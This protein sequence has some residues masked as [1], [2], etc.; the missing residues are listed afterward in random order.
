MMHLVLMAIS[1]ALTEQQ[2]KLTAEAKSSAAED[3]ATPVMYFDALVACLQSSGP[4]VSS[5]RVAAMLSLFSIVLENVS[6][7][8]LVVKFTTTATLFEAL[9]KKYAQPPIVIKPLL[10]CVSTLLIGQDSRISGNLANSLLTKLLQSLVDPHG[11]VRKYAVEY[12]LN[13][14]KKPALAQYTS[15]ML[16]HGISNTLN[17]TFKKNSDTRSAFHI[18][19]AL[20]I[21]IPF[22]STASLPQL[23]H[24]LLGIPTIGNVLMTQLAFRVFLAL[25]SASRMTAEADQLDEQASNEETENSA[26]ATANPPNDDEVDD[27]DDERDDDDDDENA[28]NDTPRTAPTFNSSTDVPQNLNAKLLHQFLKKLHDCEPN[29]ADTDLSISFA[30][31]ITEG[32]ITLHTLDAPGCALK[33]NGVFSML[34]LNLQDE[35]ERFGLKT[36]HCLIRLINACVDDEMIASTV[37][38][39]DREHLPLCRLIE[40]VHQCLNIKFRHNLDLIVDVITAL[41]KRL[42]QKSD[43]L[44]AIILQTLIDMRSTQDFHIQDSLHKAIGAAVAAMGPKQFLHYVPLTLSVDS[45]TPE[46]QDKQWM[47]PL[48]KEHISHAGLGF[49]SG[50]FLPIAER[51]EKRAQEL[52]DQEQPTT[53]KLMLNICDQIWALFPSFCDFATDVSESFTGI[54]R[55]LGD[56]LNTTE[57]V[58]TYI[59]TGFRRII[60]QNLAISSH[61][62]VKHPHVTPAQAQSNILTMQKFAKNYLP[63]LFNIYA[64]SS[65][66]AKADKAGKMHVLDTIAIYSSITKSEELNGHFTKV[67]DKLR[68][69]LQRQDAGEHMKDSKNGD[70]ET[71]DSAANTKN[72]LTRYFA[73]DLAVALIPSLDN[74]SI[75]EL[76][77]CAKPILKNGHDTRLQKKAYHTIL[78]ICQHHHTFLM[79]NTKSLLHLL[80]TALSKCAPSSRRNRLGCI[81]LLIDGIGSRPTPSTKL[82]VENTL[83]QFLGE[84]ILATKDTNRKTRLAAYDLLVYLARKMMRLPDHTDDSVHEIEG[85]SAEQL[86]KLHQFVAFL[87]AGIA[88]KSPN[89]VSSTVSALCRVIF[90]FKDVLSEQIIREL[91]S[92]ILVL[93]SNPS[94][95]ILSA[96]ISFIRLVLTILPLPHLEPFLPDVVRDLFVHLGPD[97]SQAGS[98]R[99]QIKNVLTR[100]IKKFGVEAIEAVTPEEHKNLVRYLQRMRLREKKKKTKSGKEPDTTEKKQRKSEKYDSM[101]GDD[102]SDD[103]GDDDDD[104]DRDFGKR[105]SARLPSFFISEGQQD[106]PLDLA[107]TRSFS[108][109]A[110]R[111]PPKRK[112]DEEAEL[113]ADGIRIQGDKIVIE[114]EPSEDEEDKASEADSGSEDETDAAPRKKV[115][116]SVE[117]DT[118]D[119]RETGRKAVAVPAPQRRPSKKR[120]EKPDLYLGEEYVS[121]KG[122]RGDIK[123]QGLPDPYAY[124]PLNA[125]YL[126]RRLSRK[127]LKRFAGVAGKTKTGATT[128]SRRTTRHNSKHRK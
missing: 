111:M 16:L 123:K 41:F 58:R 85:L 31:M 20:Q 49:F 114:E 105:G 24:T 57:S 3:S 45:E 84:I 117:G 1:E 54:A 36:K 48:L 15:T 51:Y 89:M 107:D 5:D 42:G 53:S 115:R 6:D 110:S 76:F 18:L 113:A 68:S 14:M 101:I 128:Q 46:A 99:E 102:Y 40:Q 67:L 34:L 8:V 38:T 64:S 78:A 26:D 126:N 116:I 91:Y 80:N 72:D 23:C 21:L 103:D 22:I 69:S 104:G 61:G 77:E 32:Y 60:T 82:T 25:F 44:L 87:S 70:K 71:T 9:F 13:L 11:K 59:C 96:V 73:V 81:R 50:Y 95:E 109:F 65:G 27:E 7:A 86:S 106:V 98:Q 94:R 2:Q 92:G 125:K 97:R 100:L 121:K 17:S 29:H 4:A 120:E 19:G 10:S 118:G 112:R 108:H 62:T 43:P 90:E 74:S 83:S 93:L 47:L 55:K 56:K 35:N 127:S 75:N 119:A 37:E 124:V 88:G 52:F 122:A 66:N 30:E 79:S 63:I 39:R 12:T 28:E 33:L